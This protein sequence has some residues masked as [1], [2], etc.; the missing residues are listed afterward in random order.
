MRLIVG[1]GNPGKTYEWT[2][3]NLG[4]QA[5]DAYASHAQASWEKH[6]KANADT[7]KIG[8]DVLL[9]K[10]LT[11]MNLS[12]QAVK[13]L[14]DFYHLRPE[15]LI[16][17]HDDKDLAFGQMRLSPGSGSAGHNGVASV[18]ESLGTQ[19]CTRIRLGIKNQKLGRM[20]T[21]AFVLAPF[22]FFEKRSIKKWLS[23]IRE[24]IDCVLQENLERCQNRF[25]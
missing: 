13:T 19:K 1:L 24:A 7:A 10:P 4:F 9:V 17:I 15:D 18:L 5:V 6:H 20:P 8:N 16:V 22:T 11:S 25:H 14:L 21:D 23:R 2:R 12:G 3:H